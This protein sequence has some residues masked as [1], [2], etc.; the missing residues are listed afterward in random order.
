MKSRIITPAPAVINCLLYCSLFVLLSLKLDGVYNYYAG[1]VC[2]TAA[3]FSDYIFSEFRYRW[4]VKFLIISITMIFILILFNAVSFLFSDSST[5]NFFDFLPYYMARDG[6]AG[7]VFIIFYYLFDSLRVVNKKSKMYYISSLIMIFLIYFLSDISSGIE[8]SLFKNYFNYSMVLL[9]LLLLIITRHIYLF[10]ADMKS[11]REKL[12]LKDYVLLLPLFLFMIFFLITFTLNDF[13]KKSGASGGLFES[14][15]FRFDFSNFLEL[16][17][18]ITLSEDRVLIVEVDGAAKL[19]NQF[20]NNEWNRQLYIKRFAL[21][22]YVS[23]GGFRS[24]SKDLEK[25][26]PPPFLSGYSWSREKPSGYDSY[27][28]IQQ[29]FYIVNIDPSSVLGCEFLYKIAPIELWKDSPFKQVYRSY[30]SV[31]TGDYMKLYADRPEQQEL[32]DDIDTNRK[33]MLLN[34]GTGR[35][36][37]L[38]IKELAEELTSGFDDPFMKA[39]IIEEYLKE[40]Y[41][42]SLKPGLSG[43][44][45]PLEYFLFDVKRG[46]CTYFAF[47]MTLMLRSLGVASRVAVGFA[48]DM[49]NRTLNFFDVRV[50][51]GH[52]WV[53]VFFDG[54]GWVV[55]DPTSSNLWPSD[56]FVFPSD[57][58]DERL[59][60]IENILNNKDSMTEIDREPDIFNKTNIY[61]LINRSLR[62]MGF[63]FPALIFLA[64]ILFLL[65]KHYMSLWLFH[66]HRINSKKTVSLWKYI[67]TDLVS[68]GYFIKREESISEFAERM[69]N[70]YGIDI[71]EISSLYQQVIF[72]NKEPEAGDLRSVLRNYKLRRKN[73]PFSKRFLS[74]LSPVVIFR[75]I[76]PLI[77][78]IILPFNLNSEDKTVFDYIYEARN[79]V[80]NSYYDKALEL[81]S[82][83]EMKFPDSHRPNY[84]MGKLYFDNEVYGAAVREF[85]K[86][87]KKGLNNEDIFVML[88]SSYARQGKDYDALRIYE[89]ALSELEESENLADNLAWMYY[90]THNY[91]KGIEFLEERLERYSKSPDVLMTL[92]TLYSSVWDYEKARQSYM[93]AVSNSYQDKFNEFRAIAYYNLALLEESFLYYDN[94][95]NSLEASLSLMQRSSGNM[96]LAYLYIR[97]ME[98]EKS[99]KHIQSASSLPP[100]TG[101]PESA[102]CYLYSISGHLDA[103]LDTAYSLLNNKDYGWMMYFG[104]TIDAFNAQTYKTLS[105]I[106]KYKSRAIF[107]SEKN[108]FF[109]VMTRVFRACGYKVMS[110]YYNIKS[111][112]AYIKL[113]ELKIDGGSDLEGLN[114]LYYAYED[115]NHSKALKI[116]KLAG[117]IEIPLN[118]NK[119]RIYDAQDA[120]LRSFILF[121]NSQKNLN[122]LLSAYNNLDDKWERQFKS[123]VLGRAAQISRRKKNEYVREEFFAEFPHLVPSFGVKIPAV[124]HGDKSNNSIIREIK[125]RGFYESYNSRIKIVISDVGIEQVNIIIRFEEMTLH[126]FVIDKKD[127]GILFYEK[128]FKFKL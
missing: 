49:N 43:R 50:N 107:Y 30:S 48:P 109:N 19:G 71:T 126:D 26:H 21:E 78:L 3:V 125:R 36:F 66:I 8:K 95:V 32:F 57:R 11:G 98:Y 127:F 70:V 79:A 84:E 44:V 54:Y 93:E 42:Y 16:K 29:T 100:K 94:A 116:S 73:L 22:E 52:A 45:S 47:S 25:D 128:L 103:A 121:G 68:L 2:I 23:P 51:D 40:N 37:E 63:V 102:L 82:E 7:V 77:L 65:L 110:L 24:A 41:H 39:V 53:E 58:K 89:E 62:Y 17:E 91:S 55:F 46:Y 59:S 69:N 60:L 113:G 6:I 80:R 61:S 18:S 112:N 87:R 120:V 4:F 104:T 114:R 105:N 33:K 5:L 9:F 111:A 99:F 34:W 67:M 118:R 75:K 119:K 92:G 56:D 106:Y 38:K 83:A 76:L 81:L 96:G 124:I 97:S 115:I 1:V 123:E 31:F 72:G 14:G 108:S 35:E 64:F 90:R 117:D 12:N 20:S 101:F 88:S 10:S 13:V 85:I 74:V 27:D 28:E 15:L 122:N 86:A